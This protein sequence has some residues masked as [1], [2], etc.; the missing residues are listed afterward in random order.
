MMRRNEGTVEGVMGWMERSGGG[1]GSRATPK[2][3][4]GAD[5]S[6]SE[7]NG[8]EDTERAAS[9]LTSD[10]PSAGSA[11]GDFT[12]ILEGLDSGWSEKIMI[13]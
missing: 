3:L 10:W 9:C 5:K 2:F 4:C 6:R 8:A 11:V 13:R 12:S 1:G 7:S